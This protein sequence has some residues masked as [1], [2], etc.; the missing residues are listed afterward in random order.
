MSSLRCLYEANGDDVKSVAILVPSPDEEEKMV[1]ISYAQ[2]CHIVDML[3]NTLGQLLGQGGG[4]SVSLVLPNSLEFVCSFLSL[5]NNGYPVSPLNPNSSKTE[6]MNNLADMKSIG[7]VVPSSPQLRKSVALDDAISAA[8]QMGL[9]ILEIG[10]R[11]FKMEIGEVVRSS[12]LASQN[13]KWSRKGAP[14]PNDIALLLQTSGTT[15]KP[16]GTGTG[17]EL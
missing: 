16:K 14:Q 11:E 7:I 1:E 5:A 8:R 13:G 6:F 15:S 9:F 2:L 17:E 4:E 12:R 10:R 3:S